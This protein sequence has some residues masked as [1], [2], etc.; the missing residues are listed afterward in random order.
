[1]TYGQLNLIFL[2]V[3]AIATWIIKSRFR[4]FTTPVVALPMLVLTALFDNLI[5]AA[6]IVGY[7]QQKLIGISVGVVP[8]E[9]FAYTIVAIL[10][11]PT[12]WKALIR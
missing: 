6:G 2:L 1:M 10:L 11:V 8:I 9:D 12:I 5:V 4:C 3:A 7:D